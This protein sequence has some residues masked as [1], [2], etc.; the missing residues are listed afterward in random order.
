MRC[1][2][3]LRATNAKTGSLRQGVS[4]VKNE[5]MPEIHCVIDQNRGQDALPYVL[6]DKTCLII[7]RK[8]R[9]CLN[10]Y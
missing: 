7:T 1:D 9:K 5:W 6:G 3:V 8:G 2:G 10:L 4:C